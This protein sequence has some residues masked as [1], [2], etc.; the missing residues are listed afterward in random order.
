M[1]M[2]RHDLSKLADD[3]RSSVASLPTEHPGRFGHKVFISAARA[4]LGGDAALSDAEFK[5]QLFAAHRAGLIQLARADLVAAMDPVAVA[6]SE[7][8]VDGATFHFVID[9]AAHD[10]WTTAR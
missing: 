1:S 5:R 9:S 7:T 2:T 10:P 6:A 8:Q 3:V 4:A